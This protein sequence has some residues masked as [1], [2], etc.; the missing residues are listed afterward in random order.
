MQTLYA[1]EKRKSQPHILAHLVL[2]TLFS[3]AEKPKELKSPNAHYC[4]KIY[5]I[6]Q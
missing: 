5:L 1:I 3:N 4:V 2:P 6:L